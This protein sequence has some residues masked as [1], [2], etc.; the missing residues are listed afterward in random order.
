VTCGLGYFRVNTRYAT[1]DGF[2][3]DIVIQRVANPFSIFGDPY[4]TAADSAD[5]NI[6][7]VVDLMPKVR[8]WTP[9]RMQ[10]VF[11]RRLVRRFRCFR[12]SGLIDAAVHV[13]AGLYGDRGSGP[14]RFRALEALGPWLVYPT[15]SSDRCAIPLV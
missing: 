4:S 7:F 13:A 3:Q 1:D 9:L 15:P 12:V 11:S 10:E 8:V 14:L 6:A 5:W 2:E